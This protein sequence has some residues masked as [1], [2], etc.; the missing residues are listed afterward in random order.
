[1]TK[2][3]LTSV[4]QLST[5]LTDI[6]EPIKATIVSKTLL[7]MN[8]KDVAT[9]TQPNPY[10][11]VW[12]IQTKHVVLNPKYEQAVNEQRAVEEKTEDFVAKERKWGVPVGTGL[13]MKEGKFYIKMIVESVETALYALVQDDPTDISAMISYDLLKPFVPIPSSS[14]SQG[15]DDVVKFQVPKMENILHINCDEFEYA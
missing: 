14:S 15:V 11:A 12:K 5:V 1:M 6:N 13:L 9:K 10:S 3:L 4:D 8:K 2:L 7:K